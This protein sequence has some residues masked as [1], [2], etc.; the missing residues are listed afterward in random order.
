MQQ[1][2]DP[3]AEHP[4]DVT[5]QDNPFRRGVAPVSRRPAPTVP[6]PTAPQ[7]PGAAPHYPTGTGWPPRPG[8]PGYPPRSTRAEE[9]RQLRIGAGWTVTGAI[10]AFVCW[11]LWAITSRGD[12]RSPVAI[13]IL[14]LLVAAGLYVL[15]RI[16]GHVVLEKQ[17]HRVRRSARGAHLVT[18]LFLAAVG[19]AYLRQID[20]VMSAVRF[21]GDLF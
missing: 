17:L 21:V 2:S 13:F 12:L 5:P 15:A 6:Q 1:P 4:I 14:T 3:W 9:M 11:G 18:G 7:R 8:E 19:I 20:W 10:F 16:V